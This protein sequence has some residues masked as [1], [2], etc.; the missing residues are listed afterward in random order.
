MV[1]CVEE[2]LNELGI[3]GLLDVEAEM[4]LEGR[5]AK[6]KRIE[7]LDTWKK[8]G[9]SDSGVNNWKAANNSGG[10]VAQ[11]IQNNELRKAVIRQATLLLRDYR[12]YCREKERQTSDKK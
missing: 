2:T 7:M 6:M 9:A 1:T 12:H 3:L 8:V 10:G 4:H 5:M 11:W